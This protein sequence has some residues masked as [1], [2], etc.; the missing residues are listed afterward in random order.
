MNKKNQDYDIVLKQD[1]ENV[2]LRLKDGQDK[3]MNTLDTVMKQL[4]TIQEEQTVGF[5]QLDELVIM[6]NGYE[7]R[8]K[9]L[10]KTIAA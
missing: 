7:K 2:E 3:I 5:G 6:A 4:E 9:K 8:I 1:L 10:E